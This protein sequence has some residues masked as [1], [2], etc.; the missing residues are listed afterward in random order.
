V[1]DA[2]ARTR[3]ASA[4]V[5]AILA[6]ALVLSVVVGTLLVADQRHRA[7][8]EADAAVR[9][10]AAS[11]V[12]SVAAEI[13]TQLTQATQAGAD[14]VVRPVAEVERLPHLLPLAVRARDTGLPVLADLAEPPSIVVPVYA[15][16]ANPQPADPGTTAA[17]RAAIAGF[18][19]VPLTLGPVLARLAP[20]DGGVDVRGPDRTVATT[21]S[22]TPPASTRSFSVS[23]AL[24]D[25][26]G[27]VVAAWVPVPGMAAAA[28]GWLLGMLVLFGGLA[29]VG[30]TA[31]RRWSAAEE[32]RDRVDRQRSLVSGLAPLVQASLDL[33]E[34]APAVSSHL[35]H[36]LSLAGISLSAPS[37]DTGE[38]PLFTWGTPPDARV[39]PHR[40]TPD[41]L[42]AGSTFAVSLTR[43]GRIL[44]VLRVVAGDPLVRAD[45]DALATATELL[46]SALAHVEMF[47][48]QQQV[49][50]RLRS[51]DEL[52]TV[53]L[54][55]ASHELRTPTTAIVGFSALLL[56]EWDD[57]DLVQ[58]RMFLER[59]VSNARELESLIEQLLDFA[60]LE[61]GV[62]PTDD[63][64]LDLGAGI[65]G[66]LAARPE[67][68]AQHRLESD[69][70]PG[71]MIRGSAAAMERIVT[72][73]VGNAG[74]YSPPGTRILVTVRR[75][76]GRITLIVDDEGPG[77]PAED[78]EHV[79]SRFYRGH[80]TPV[81]STRGAGIGLAI[82][83]EYAACMAGTATVA[84]APGGGARFVVTFPA[85]ESL[86]PAAPPAP[87][88]AAARS[89]APVNGAP[90]VPIS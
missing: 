4:R 19:L 33:G 68:A 14:S 74:K 58:G 64:L 50:D 44:G 9:A 26:T 78:R 71:C 27:W 10:A 62:R 11:A 49:V 59:V 79:F 76:A 12:A 6:L 47:A 46:G 85:A 70:A 35:V 84:D 24:P 29:A 57:L 45:L 2:A 87:R 34:V 60:R 53:F 31:A 42:E 36:T 17:R 52:K 39:L 7:R 23:L 5:T 65:E 3:R 54:A 88:T 25:A 1:T 80:G 21:A 41:R 13:R 56:D 43:G 67:L 32:R 38:R 82:V 8:L 63:E 66:I 37:V 40:E 69:L 73:L 15:V 61:R 22:G 89:E 55:T 81:T 20:E 72:N 83:A 75:D 86:D 51:I 16:G 90:R 48:R 28:W 18:R 30:V 77:V